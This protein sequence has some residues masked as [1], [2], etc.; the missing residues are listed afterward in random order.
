VRLLP[1][2]WRSLPVCRASWRSRRLAIFSPSEPSMLMHEKSENRYYRALFEQLRR[3][4]HIEGQ[5]LKVEKLG[6]DQNK[7]GPA[8]LAAEVLGSNPEIVYVVGP[9]AVLFSASRYRERCWRPRT[10]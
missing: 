6:L 7:S 2:R 8:A 3:L 10:M 9:G 1:A 5:N 4:G